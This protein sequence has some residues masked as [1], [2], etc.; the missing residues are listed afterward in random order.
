MEF[1]KAVSNPMLMGCIELMKEEDTPEHRNMFVTELTKAQLLSPALMEPAPEEDAEGNLKPLPGTKVQ[2]PMLSTSDGKKFLM[3]FTDRAE[4]E[5]WQE[6][7]NQKLP[8]FALR[9][10]DYATLLFGRNAQGNT[11]PGLGF[12]INP[13]GANIIVPKE[14]VAGVMAAKAAQAKK[15]Q[16]SGG[17]N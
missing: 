5:S 12:V 6:K 11:T 17:Q 2:F 13:V 4:Y 14:M 3:A 15:Q 8:T 7:S 16:E 9:F 1:N 10:E